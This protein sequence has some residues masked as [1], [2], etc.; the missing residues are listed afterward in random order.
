MVPLVGL[1]CVIVALPGH[2]YFLFN[3]LMV[4]FHILVFNNIV[5]RHEAEYSSI[6][7]SE[8]CCTV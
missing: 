7:G 5:L 4:C 2:F 1:Q 6:R 3:I 8:N